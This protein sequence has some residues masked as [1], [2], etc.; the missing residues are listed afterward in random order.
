[1]LRKW[2]RMRRGT[3]WRREEK[4][5]EEEEKEEQKEEGGGRTGKG[6][7]GGRRGGRRT[8]RRR[9]R[10]EKFISSIDHIKYVKL[11]ISTYLI[12]LLLLHVASASFPFSLPQSF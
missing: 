9:R 8:G 6:Q 12:Y 11:L 2:E 10:K 4:E 1:M 7:R 5:E 3:E